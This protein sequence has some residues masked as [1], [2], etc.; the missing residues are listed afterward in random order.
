[1]KTMER[2]LLKVV[3]IQLILLLTVQI[4]LHL[5]KGELFLSKVVQYEGVNNISIEEWIETFKQ[6]D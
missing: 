2:W 1:M 6:K 5:T 3:F 4:T